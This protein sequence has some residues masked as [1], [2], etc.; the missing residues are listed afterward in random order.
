MEYQCFVSEGGSPPVAHVHCAAAARIQHAHMIKTGLVRG[1][2]EIE[3][4][5]VF[6]V[7]KSRL[8][9]GDISNFS[10]NQYIFHVR[11]SW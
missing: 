6:K 7:K 1:H 4:W 3:F 8:G 10:V 11:N 5:F 9:L 2:F